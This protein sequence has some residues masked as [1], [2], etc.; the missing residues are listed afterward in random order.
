MSIARAL[1]Y[2][3]LLSVA[4]FTEAGAAVAAL[5]HADVMAQQRDLPLPHLALVCGP[6]GGIAFH[7]I[8][9]CH[10]VAEGTPDGLAMTHQPGGPR[11]RAQALAWGSYGG[12]NLLQHTA[13]L[14]HGG[15]DG[16]V[17]KLGGRQLRAIGGRVVTGASSNY[18]GLIA[19]SCPWQREVARD[20]RLPQGTAQEGEIRGGCDVRPTWAAFQCSSRS[21]LGGSWQPPRVAPFVERAGGGVRGDHLPVSGVLERG[22]RM[23]EGRGRRR[24][25]TEPFHQPSTSRAAEYRSGGI[26][27]LHPPC[28]SH[29]VAGRIACAEHGRGAARR[30]RPP[31][32]ATL[33]PRA[34][35]AVRSLQ[36]ETMIIGLRHRRR[37]HHVSYDHTR[38]NTSVRDPWRRARQHHRYTGDLHTSGIVRLCRS[39]FKRGATK[40]SPQRPAGPPRPC[41]GRYRGGSLYP[42]AWRCPPRRLRAADRRLDG[43]L[44]PYPPR[45]HDHSTPRWGPLCWDTVW[46]RLEQ[47]V[48][49][50]LLLACSLCPASDNHARAP[51]KPPTTRWT[52]GRWAKQQYAL[53][54][55]AEGW[56]AVEAR[57]VGHRRRPWRR[58]VA[59]RVNVLM[60]REAEAQA[61]GRS[62][63]RPSVETAQTYL[64]LRPFEV[65]TL[66]DVATPR[67]TTPRRPEF[68]DDGFGG[69]PWTG[70]PL[71]GQDLRH[72]EAQLAEILEGL[73]RGRTLRRRSPRPAAPHFPPRPPVLAKQPAVE[74]PCVAARLGRGHRAWGGPPRVWATA[75][76]IVHAYCGGQAPLLFTI[77]AHGHLIHGRTA[78]QAC[79]EEFGTLAIGQAANLGPPSWAARVLRPMANIAATAAG[80]LL[81][82]QLLWTS[83]G[84]TSPLRYPTPGKQGFHGV[85]TAGFDVQGP[86]LEPF[87]LEVMTANTTGWRQL[88]KLLEKTSAHVVFAQEH[89]LTADEVPGAS[90]WARRH[91]WKSV[92]TPA[93]PGPAGGPSA[94]TV[95]LA[96]DFCGL[97]HPDSGP[98]EVV[99]GRVVSAAVEAPSMRPFV[100][101]AAY[102]HDGQELGRDNLGLIASIAAHFQSQGDDRLQFIVAADF[103]MQPTTIARSG[104]ASQMRGAVVAPSNARGTCRTRTSARTIDFF[105]TCR[106]LWRR[107]S[108]TSTP[109]KVQEC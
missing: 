70:A 98:S 2:I 23:Q 80:G 29:S 49:G 66:E 41:C 31:P 5:S 84:V 42:P 75:V 6:R 11:G 40:T 61:L 1:Y 89:R 32:L 108:A 83:S 15:E 71:R 105:S 21:S 104:L 81:D 90:A 86:P 77:A 102:F 25:S 60:R 57:I 95:V 94:G 99:P 53:H 109:L 33:P 101:Y 82:A 62:R 74:A 73:E 9:A 39:F 51:T 97:R 24:L 107:S 13:D 37:L 47:I 46:V 68:A 14:Q 65:Q 91:G 69:A 48:L 92:W 58:R 63:R 17:A 3:L 55:K 76:G 45:D 18:S 67:S 106:H 8:T 96:Q 10:S 93:V 87:A 52:R 4:A 43:Q 79:L 103:N 50:I 27:P 59:G 30:P 54:V 28:S 38:R 78:A 44:M 7:H 64:R 26:E 16:P 100:G 19:S 12:C 22:T 34:A 72:A 36:G 20:A 88:R 56:L 35:S 85:H